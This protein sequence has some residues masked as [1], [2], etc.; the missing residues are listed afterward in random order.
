MQIRKNICAALAVLASI[1]GVQSAALGQSPS[2]N[3]PPLKEVRVEANAFSLGDP[4]PTWVETVE[5]PAVTG[6]RSL[7]RLADTQFLVDKVPTV[8]ARRS[9]DIGD[10]SSLTAAGQIPISFSPDYQRLVVHSIGVVR[11]GETQDRTKAANVRFLQR[12]L[13]LEHGVYSDQVTASILVNDLRVGDT[14]EYAFSLVGQNPVFGNKFINWSAWEQGQTTLL[15]R[16]ILRHPVDRQ[17]SWRMA[18]SERATPVAVETA[19]DAGVRR[20]VF[21]ERDLAPPINE[22]LT[23]PD[24]PPYR[25]LQFSEFSD[26]QDVAVWAT[27]LFRAPARPNADFMKV[28]EKLR[29]PASTEERVAAALEFVQSEIRYFSVSLGENSHRPAT[30][31]LVL[32]RRYGDCKDK[33]FLLVALLSEM[34]IPAKPVLIQNGRR[35]ILENALPSPQLFDHVIVQVSVDGTN[36]YLDPTRLGQHGRLQRMGQVHEGAEILVVDPGTSALSILAGNAVA[37]TYRNELSDTIKLPT[38]NGEAQLESRQVVNGVLAEYFR[39]LF[40]RWPREQIIRS[41]GDALER[42]YPGTKL[43]GEPELN[44]DRL[45]N[46][47][48]IT[49]RYQVPKLLEENDSYWALRYVPSNMQGRLPGSNSATRST[50]LYLGSHPYSGKYSLEATFPDDIMMAVDP[51]TKTVEDKHFIYT[52]GG[53]FRGNRA[54]AS[55]ELQ[56]LND[57]V[58]AAD[59]KEYSS[60][61]R[62]AGALTRGRFIVS[63]ESLR[64]AAAPLGNTGFPERL[65][66]RLEQGIEK[67]TASIGLGKLKGEDLG[68]V[69]C[70]RATTVSD[71][72]RMDDALKDANEALRIA[73]NSVRVAL[74]R[75]EIYFQMGQFEKSIAEY[76]RGI[77]LG[78]TKSGVFYGRGVSKFYAGQLENA[79]ADFMQASTIEDNESSLYN[80]LWL[81][82]T[83]QRLG[84]PLPE[85]LVKRTTAQAHGEWPR[86]ALAMLMGSLTPDEL[87]KIANEKT[88]DERE[89][90]LSEGYFYIG[91]Y[92]KVRGDDARAAEYFDKTQKQ[93]IL[94]YREHTA[95]KHEL[96]HIKKA[97]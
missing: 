15:R 56:V 16:V 29:L 17:V 11:G 72:G 93:G 54:V 70:R 75:A 96:A 52:V 59:L 32:E 92:Y 27:E 9:L 64:S 19:I 38:M 22:P 42:Q 95:S 62:D 91:Q 81:T 83:F 23:P 67:M 10:A 48:S 35:R 61:V 63:K 45:N 50:P 47:F 69:Y 51:E 30:P 80:D 53:S 57:R 73:P 65:R 1:I 46:V 13:G 85:A 36:F 66:A 24:T 31:D 4:L 55:I 97:Q 94:F 84:R 77:S 78:D 39:V 43:A 7:I 2:P 60:R 18:G 12:E 90:T 89:M 34:G 82:W 76:S 40:Q 87:I 58:E 44:D 68:G 21:E 28:V 26:W 3:S 20:L 37:E 79:A 33:S 86:P 49:A 8:F 88:G 5:V 14:L 71:L 25:L 74:C 41:F 6:T